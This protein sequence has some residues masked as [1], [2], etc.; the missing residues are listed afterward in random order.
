[1]TQ[2][3]AGAFLIVGWREW[4]ALPDFGIRLIKAK[5]DS[6]ARTSALHVERLELFER[7]AQRWVRF[8][9]MPRSRRSGRSMSAEAPVVDQRYVTDSGGDRALRPFIRTH[10]V[11]GEHV[12]EVEMNLTN[13]RGMLFPM[14]LGRTAMAG[15]V[16]VDPSR[17]FLLGRPHHRT[18]RPVVT[19]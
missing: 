9:L 11:L 15:K 18:A 8:E 3:A 12:I 13:R 10:V 2:T 19:P 14:L 5:L 4:L 17:S 6:G 7:G 16:L 1:V